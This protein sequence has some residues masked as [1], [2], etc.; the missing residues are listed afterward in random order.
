[1]SE[2]EKSRRHN[3]I[4]GDFGEQTI[5][6]MLSKS[7]FECVHADYTGIDIIATKGT[8]RIGVSVKCRT[9]TNEKNNKSNLS[10]EN[11][12]FKKIDDACKEFDVIPYI[13][14]VLDTTSRLYIFVMTKEHFLK[15]SPMGKSCS[16][17]KMTTKSIESYMNDPNIKCKLFDNNDSKWF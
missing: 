5:L 9:R 11:D 16:S 15:I 3:K 17:W 8:E 13:G 12:N 2:I 6:Y 1:M 7:G 10:I 14:L 4:C